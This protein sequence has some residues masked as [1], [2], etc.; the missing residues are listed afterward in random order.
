MI[1]IYFFTSLLFIAAFSFINII[2]NDKHYNSSLNK[3]NDF[4]KPFGHIIPAILLIVIYFSFRIEIATYWNQLITDST[5]KLNLNHESSISKIQYDYDLLRFKTIWIYIY[6]LFFFSI[7]LLVNIRLLK[8]LQL[9][10]INLGLSAIVIIFF[11]FEAL[12]V[13]SELRDSY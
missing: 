6:S 3:G 9:G 5:I 13:L 2:N 12:F 4:F 7:L 8:I 11:L 1:N 10:L